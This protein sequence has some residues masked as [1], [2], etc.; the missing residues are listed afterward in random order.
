MIPPQFIKPLIA[1]LACI[2]LA[3]GGYLKGRSDAQQAAAEQIGSLKTALSGSEATVVTLR[4][5]NQ[6]W[7]KLAE[8]WRDQN[9]GAVE[10]LNRELAKLRG[11][12]AR[13]RRELD[14]VYREDPDA[15]AWA[16]ARVPAAVADRLRQ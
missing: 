5:A 7:A 15:A 6:R 1:L 2:A 10:R 12:N 3:V 4:Q 11:D 16:G 8:D 9:D 14:E 13:L